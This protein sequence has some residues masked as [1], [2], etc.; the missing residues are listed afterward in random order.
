M[1]DGGGLGKKL[2]PFSF[3]PGAYQRILYAIFHAERNAT[4]REL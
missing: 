2:P 1:R 4:T 3:I